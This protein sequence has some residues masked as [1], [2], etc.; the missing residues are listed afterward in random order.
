MFAPDLVETKQRNTMKLT[1]RL[2]KTGLAGT[3]ALVLAATA[4]AADI[5][6]AVVFDMGGKFDKSF[7]QGV[8][9]V[10]YTHL[11]LPTILLV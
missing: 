8:Y 4:T 1:S 3:A 10:S 9:A 6:P 5:E 11:T 7:N 2:L